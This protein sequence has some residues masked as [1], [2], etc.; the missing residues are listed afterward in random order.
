MN[1]Q[2]SPNT[3]FD[4]SEESMANKAVLFFTV[5]FFGLSILTGI[6]AIFSKVV[7]TQILFY[8]FL[9]CFSYIAFFFVATLCCEDNDCPMSIS[10]RCVCAIFGAGATCLLFLAIQF[11]MLGVENSIWFFIPAIIFLLMGIVLGILFYFLIDIVPYFEG[12]QCIAK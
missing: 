5:A 10:D 11:F 9:L 6:N 3:D 1:Q 4:E 12:N 8:I 2:F 7:L